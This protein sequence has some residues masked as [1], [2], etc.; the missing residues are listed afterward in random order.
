MDSSD[1]KLGSFDK[2]AAKI[3]SAMNWLALSQDKVN[4][5]GSAA[6]YSL[7]NGW[8]AS[9]PETTGYIIPAFI[10]YSRMKSKEEFFSRALDMG[11]W[12][13][14]LQSREGWFPGGYKPSPKSEPSIFNSAQIIIGLINLYE[15]TDKKEYLESAKACA[16]WLV[17]VQ[18]HDGSW[19]KGGYV[20]N[21]SPS[22]YSRVSWPILMVWEKDKNKKLYDSAKKSLNTIL[23]KQNT[24]LSFKDWAFKPGKPAFTHTI[25]YTIRGFL[26]SAFILNEWEKY[27]V[28]AEK[29]AMKLF[30]LFEL[31]KYLAG[32]YYQDWSPVK[33]Y[34]CLTGNCQIAIC[35]LILYEINNDPRLLN[36]AI[37][38][39][40]LTSEKQ[41]LR[42]IN[43]NIRGAIPG[44]SPIWGRYMTMRYPNWAAKF[45]VDALMKIETNLRKLI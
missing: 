6:Y 16:E 1:S 39:V 19:L 8:A 4:R 18:C 11:K 43:K 3:D 2:Y 41:K 13:L 34:T 38:L 15:A 36:A 5:Q 9:Y 21:Y 40:N 37:K 7:I 17:S 12:L 24:N 35:W 28:P 10:N 32:A 33:W 26:E 22:Y 30:R 27:G 20:K 44:S 31:K 14:N 23:L 25:A 29:T 45:Y 42:S